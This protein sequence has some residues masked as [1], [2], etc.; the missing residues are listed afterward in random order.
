MYKELIYDFILDIIA[1]LY[2]IY[3]G[4]NVDVLAAIYFY[5]ICSSSVLVISYTTP[6][7][8]SEKQK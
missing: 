8:Q 3:V 7:G 4:L 2:Q 6:I 1:S 5:V